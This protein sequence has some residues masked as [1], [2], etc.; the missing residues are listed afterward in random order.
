MTDAPGQ[1]SKTLEDPNT[2]AATLY[3]RALRIP[4]LPEPNR[5]DA[6]TTIAKHPNLNA[7]TLHELAWQIHNLPEPN[8]WDA[9][10]TIAKHPDLTPKPCTNWP[11]RSTTCPKTTSQTPPPPSPNTRTQPPKP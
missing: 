8:R 5:W 3:E 4:H 11:G 2:T 9:F 7:K 6:F 1:T 10:T